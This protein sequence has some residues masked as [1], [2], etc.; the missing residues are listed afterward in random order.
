MF[1]AA[2]IGAS[3]TG[4]TC[5]LCRAEVIAAQSHHILAKSRTII[6]NKAHTYTQKS[7]MVPQK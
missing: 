6:M 4:A 1:Y 3:A 2:R 5:M 7:Y